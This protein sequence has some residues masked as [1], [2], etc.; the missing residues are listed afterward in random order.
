MENE[1]TILV[2]K[3][4]GKLL[5]SLQHRWDSIKLDLTEETCGL[6]LFG[7]GYCV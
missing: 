1:Y 3:H 2:L 4:K 7:G 5:G 6:G